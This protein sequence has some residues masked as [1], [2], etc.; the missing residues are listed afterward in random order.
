MHTTATDRRTLLRHATHDLHN[1]LDA[2][3]SRLDF[4]QRADY[5]RYLLATAGPII[6]LE[7]AFE[8]NRV[9]EV[10]T[11]WSRRRRRFALAL[12]LHALGL[13]ATAADTRRIWTRSSMLGAMYVLEGSRLGAQVLLRR[14]NQSN[15]Q[16]VLA[17][18]HFLR[19]SDPAPWS[20][21]LRTLENAGEALDVDEM[22]AAAR[23]TFGLFGAA[24]AKYCSPVTT[25]SRDSSPAFA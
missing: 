22:V 17:A 18:R 15:D 23:E 25:R 1:E 10:F 13:T 12:D 8:A 14:V 21:F 7:V 16:G 4:G 3:A 20:S 9:E 6:G 19:G 2:V 24:F 5:C 11:D